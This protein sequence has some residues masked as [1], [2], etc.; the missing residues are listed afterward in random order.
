MKFIKENIY[1]IILFVFTLVISLLLP[2]MG[3]DWINY[4]NKGMSFKEI[5]DNAITFYQGW[6]GR[7]F[8]RITLSLLVPNQVIWAILNA[9]LMTAFY[10]M[11]IKIIGD[12]YKKVLYPVLLMIILFV[13]PSTFA[14][15]YVW[16]TGNI[17]YFIPLVYMIYLIY[18]RRNLLNGSEIKV[19]KFE[20]LLIPLTF[21]L[22]MYIENVSVGIVLVCLFNL[23]INYVKNK[24][25]DFVM[26]GC[27]IASIIGLLLMS[28]SPGNFMRLE[29]TGDFNNLNIFE[30]VLYNYPNFL[31]YTFMCTPMVIILTFTLFILFINN[32][33][34]NKFIKLLIIIYLGFIPFATLCGNF[35]MYFIK[36][37]FLT[38]IFDIKRFDIQFFWSVYAIIFIVVLVWYFRKYKDYRPLYFIIIGLLCNLAMMISPIWDGRTGYL[39]YIMFAIALVMIILK[40]NEKVFDNKIVRIGGSTIAIIFMVC[41]TIYSGYIYKQNLL[42]NKYINYQ[43]QEKKE[44]FE[45]LSLPSYYM[46]GVNVWSSLGP[47]AESFKLSNGIPI[48]SRLTML[49]RDN[50]RIDLDKLKT[51]SK[52]K[53]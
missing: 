40:L 28:F 48:N 15:I 9:G 34:K 11:I 39:T 29:T 41:F 43:I 14:Q 18:I 31:N 1:P 53:V 30:K 51:S 36:I 24:K 5:I 27:L 25:I 52:M 22:S 23:I 47:F 21:I 26:L 37:Q 35:L 7:F 3:D 16:K 50:I 13:E 12:K 49:E 19:N 6:E 4:L 33:V 42:R 20:Y 46:W 44:D 38:Y 2:L 45:I 32:F 10:V 17:T 8:S